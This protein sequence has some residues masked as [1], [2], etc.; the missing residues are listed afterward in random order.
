MINSCI[1]IGRV[2]TEIE[3]KKTK[4][5]VSCCSFQI[6][7]QRRKSD[8]TDYPPMAAYGKIAEI[9]CSYVKKGDRVGV[10]ASYQSTIKNEKK[11]YE[12]KIEEIEFLE[13]KK[14]GGYDDV[15]IPHSANGECFTCDF[16]TGDDDLPF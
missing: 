7:V 11:Y 12:F 8:K 6:A 9:I 14:T 5:N 13:S 1:F 16:V 4:D 10:R 3:L 15:Q 2:S